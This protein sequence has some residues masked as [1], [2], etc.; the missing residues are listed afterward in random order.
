MEAFMSTLIGIWVDRS[1]AIII[2]VNDKKCDTLTLLSDI[3]NARHPRCG[4]EGRCTMIPERRMEKRK[5]EIVRKFYQRIVGTI[6][7]AGAILI[8]G[9]GMAKTELISEFDSIRHLRSRIIG[10]E[11][12]GRMSL[13][14]L[15]AKVKKIFTQIVSPPPIPVLISTC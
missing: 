12:A 7:D 3:E 6:R 13:K 9:P 10:I 2:R 5:Q 15:E 14:Q 1:K 8:L 4:T 11:T